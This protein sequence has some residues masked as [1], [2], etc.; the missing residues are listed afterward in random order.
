METLGKLFGSPARVKIM[1]LFLLNPDQVFE[2]RSIRTK[3]NVDASTAR[4]ELVRLRSI[5]FIKQKSA[6]KT[7]EQKRG[8]RK[9]A[10]R[11]T[12][13]GLALDPT[14]PYIASMRSM[15]T[16]SA[17]FDRRSILA[18]FRDVGKL[19]V[20][21]VSGVFI[22]QEHSRV[23]ILLVADSF[24]RKALANALRGLEAEIGKDI[25]Y[26]ALKTSDFTY[27][28]NIYDKFVRDVL[29]Y[30]HERLIDRLNLPRRPTRLP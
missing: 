18:R 20:L 4:H 27:R 2:V 11:K 7:I 16:S 17:S 21:I 9:V 3:S 24:R 5:G 12:I 13:Q 23:D 19:K 30:P 8:R 10:T 26:T 6:S 29:D 22:Q 1:R 15:L 14:F 25:E 28:L